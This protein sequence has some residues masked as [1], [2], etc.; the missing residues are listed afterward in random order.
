MI[1]SFMLNPTQQQAVCVTDKPLLILAGAGSGKTKVITQKIAYLLNEQKISA[2]NIYALTFTN[3]AA[4]EMASRVKTLTTNTR[5]LTIATFHNFGYKIIQN[6]KSILNLKNNISIYD[7]EDTSKLVREITQIT[8]KERIQLILNQISAIKNTGTL[9]LEK[10]NT[11]YDPYIIQLFAEYNRTLRS[12]NAVDLDDLIYLPLQLFE[13]HPEILHQWQARVRYLLVDEY[14]DTNIAQYKLIHLLTKTSGKLTVV[15]DDHQSIY[16]WRGANV[17]NLQQLQQ[18][19]YNLHIIKLEQNYRSMGNILAAA[20]ALIN[21]NENLFNKNLWSD[22]GAG[23]P[24][25]VIVAQN[26]AEEADKVSALIRHKRFLTQNNFNQYA[27]LYRSNHQSRAFEKAL[28]AFEIPYQISGG[29]SFFA[30]TEIKD[31]LAYLKVLV[32]PAD[33]LSF[34]RIIN[35][36][37][38]EIGTQTLEK[39]GKYAKQ[40]NISLF[41][42]IFELGLEQS[43]S[44]KAIERLRQVGNW[45]NLLAHELEQG[46]TTTE[47]MQRVIKDINFDAYIHDTAANSK[48]AEKKLQNIQELIAWLQKLTDDPDNENI[49]LAQALHKLQLIDLLSRQNEAANFNCVQLMT[50]HAAKGLEFDYV[51]ITGMLEQILPHQNSIDTDNIEEE[52]RLAYVAITR[53]KLELSISFAKQ[54]SNFKQTQSSQ[55]SRFLEEMPAELFEWDDPDTPQETKTTQQQ[56]KANFSLLQELLTN[57]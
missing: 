12:Y 46:A 56:S 45:F 44:F 31:L 16:A 57:K 24:I 6:A 39:L 8:E 40:R 11:Q 43:L 18:D 22:K 37:K 35:T 21:H 33:D 41:D 25:K 2:S 36:P 4:R 30:R 15:G 13:Q 52:R 23:V 19:F 51:Y 42:A 55:P 3:K 48:Q 1:A 9:N 10:L 29:T 27:I 17:A 49:T 26:E 32:N 34:L 53:A 7:Q 28:R 5:G 50:I 14:Q 54:R 47:V 20:N 38:R